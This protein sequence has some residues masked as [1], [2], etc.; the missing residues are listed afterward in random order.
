[1]RVFLRFEWAWWKKENR[2]D[3]IHHSFQPRA[4]GHVHVCLREEMNEHAGGTKK[5]QR[6]RPPL[7]PPPSHALHFF[8]VAGAPHCKDLLVGD[9]PCHH[10]R[11]LGVHRDERV[12]FHHL[13]G[14]TKI[15][16]PT[17]IATGK[18]TNTHGETRV[19]KSKT[20]LKRC[21]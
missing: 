20:R 15:Y 12:V 18:Q 13:Y 8:V 19:H 16:P 4:E 1:M 2:N 3:T 17:N 11:K 9:W 10:A 5:T 14:G 7:S 6:K 21:Y